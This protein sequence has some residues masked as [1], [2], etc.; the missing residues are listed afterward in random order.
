[1][2]LLSSVCEI[3]H[4][5]IVSWL[6]FGD[7]HKK[8]RYEKNIKMLELIATKAV[9]ELDNT[10]ILK[11]K[12]LKNSILIVINFNSAMLHAL[13]GLPLYYPRRRR[14]PL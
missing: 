13:K 14:L 12:N 6:L 2:T 9:S 1:M 3:S 11:A 10:I 4:L 8:L 7:E 5:S